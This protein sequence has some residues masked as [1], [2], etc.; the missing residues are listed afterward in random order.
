VE[1]MLALLAVLA[2]AVERHLVTLLLLVG[3]A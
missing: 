2:V 3:K 1:R